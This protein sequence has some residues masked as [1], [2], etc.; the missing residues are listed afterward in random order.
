MIT[1]EEYKRLIAA[2][3]I[4]NE[5]IFTQE[6]FYFDTPDFALK[7]LGSALRIRKKDKTYEMTLKQPADIGLLE[8]NQTIN[9]DDTSAALDNSG[10]PYGKVQQCIEE[11]NI[12]FSKLKYLGSLKTNRVEFEYMNGLLVLDHSTYLNTEDYEV[13]YEV[14]DYQEGQEIFRTFL[15][16]FNI[17]ERKTKNKIHRL[18]SQLKKK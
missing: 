17:P 15:S 16:Q 1:K 7:N 18:Y 11:K 13:E 2:F 10:L 8:T 12:P 14:K 4:A 9:A 5:Q 3:N 6:N